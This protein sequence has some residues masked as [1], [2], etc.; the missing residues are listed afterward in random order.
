MIWLLLLI[1]GV[2]IIR[3]WMQWS[4]AEQRLKGRQ[5]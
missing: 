4:I 2:L 5:R 1:P 3:W